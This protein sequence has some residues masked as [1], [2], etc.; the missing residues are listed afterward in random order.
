MFMSIYYCIFNRDTDSVGL[1]KAVHNCAREE[2]Y[3]YF[4]ADE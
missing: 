2:S 3:P 4:D 1:A